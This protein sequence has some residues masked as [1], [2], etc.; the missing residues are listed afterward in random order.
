MLGLSP[1]LSPLLAVC[2]WTS[3][4]TCLSL[5]KMDLFLWQL[6][7]GWVMKVE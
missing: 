4:L 3:H 1:G 6:D 7:L 2:P 5:T